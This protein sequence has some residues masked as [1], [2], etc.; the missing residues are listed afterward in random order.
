MKILF[1]IGVFTCLLHVQSERVKSNNMHVIRIPNL[2]VPVKTYTEWSPWSKCNNCWQIR[3]VLCKGV[4]CKYKAK[5]IERKLCECDVQNRDKGNTNSSIVTSSLK[6]GNNGVKYHNS[7]LKNLHIIKEVPK[8]K[9]KRLRGEEARNWSRWSNWSSCTHDCKTSRYKVC[10]TPTKCKKKRLFESAYC[11]VE[12]TLCE[13]VVWNKMSNFINTGPQDRINYGDKFPN[14]VNKYDS[15]KRPQRKS[16]QCGRPKPN[17]LLKIIG[18]DISHHNRW[19]WNAALIKHG[20]TYC[21]GTLIAPRFVLTAAHCLRSKMYIRFREFDLAFY[22]GDEEEYAVDR[23]IQHPFYNETTVV[24]DIA[25]LR[26]KK[27]VNLPYACLPK[28][29]KPLDVNQ[30]C[31]VM[32]WGKIHASHLRGSRFLRETKIPIRHIEDCIKAYQN[33]P[34]S[35]KNM[36]C[37]GYSRGHRDTCAGDSGAG[38][39]CACSKDEDYGMLSDTIQGITSFGDGC[40]TPNKF[41]VYTKVQSYLAWIKNTIRCNRKQAKY[42]H[43]MC[44]NYQWV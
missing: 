21:S 36:I 31:S 7:V 9:V 34:I 16:R 42:Y 10:K 29:N 2:N 22:N 30:N 4:N 24:N 44:D 19:P 43:K 26:L 27:A 20:E 32:G 13:Q 23:Y 35:R 6:S 11:F 40:G 37:A 1:L 41:G 14:K 17:K 12:N 28:L 39:M 15:P 25:L 3:K 8:K 5:I 33:N 18:G 38:L